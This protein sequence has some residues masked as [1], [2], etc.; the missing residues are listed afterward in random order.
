MSNS[1]LVP[2]SFEPEP[3]DSELARGINAAEAYANTDIER[4]VGKIE[5][6]LHDE[7]IAAHSLGE[8]TLKLMGPLTDIVPIKIQDVLPRFSFPAPP[9]D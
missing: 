9:V 7:W 8:T 2:G 5:Q 4:E 6:L 3:E 1:L